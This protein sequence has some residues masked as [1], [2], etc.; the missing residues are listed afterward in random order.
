MSLEET[1]YVARS[2]ETKLYAKNLLDLMFELEEFTGQTKFDNR[3]VGFLIGSDLIF[4]EDILQAE[5]W[6]D[7]FVQH[8]RDSAPPS[9]EFIVITLEEK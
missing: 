8:Y 3:H 6:S 4:T 5:L 7:Y 9:I 2:I 1:L